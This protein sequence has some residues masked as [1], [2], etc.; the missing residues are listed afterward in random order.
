MPKPSELTASCTSAYAGTCPTSGAKEGPCPST[1]S[2][3]ND[4]SHGSPVPIGIWS[5]SGPALATTTCRSGPSS[6]A[7]PTSASSGVSVGGRVTVS[8]QLTIHRSS[9]TD[10]CRCCTL[11]S[12]AVTNPR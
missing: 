10:A 3:Q 7:A 5:A 9:P 8:T 12:A 11:S 1:I 2:R 4:V 6:P